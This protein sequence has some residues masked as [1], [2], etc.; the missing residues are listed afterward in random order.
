ML[1]VQYIAGRLVAPGSPRQSEKHQKN[2][3]LLHNEQKS[4][5]EMFQQIQS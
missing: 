2:S 3:S 1:S 4:K 5:S